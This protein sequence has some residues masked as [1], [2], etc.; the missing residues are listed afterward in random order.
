[1][2]KPATKWNLYA[3]AASAWM[4]ILSQ[5]ENAK[6]KAITV[7]GVVK[8]WLLAGVVRAWLIMPPKN[9][10]QERSNEVVYLGI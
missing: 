8:A 4:T 3:P 5:S 6:A 9:G 1:M 2:D 10:G 7:V